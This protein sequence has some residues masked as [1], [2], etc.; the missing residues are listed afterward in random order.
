MTEKRENEKEV[1][2]LISMLTLDEKKMLYALLQ[3]MDIMKK[4]GLC[5]EQKF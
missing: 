5:N 1:R 3:T 4:R 2:K